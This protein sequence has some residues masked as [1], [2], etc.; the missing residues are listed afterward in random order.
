MTTPRPDALTANEEAEFR[1]DHQHAGPDAA[2]E[3]AS[4]LDPC[5]IARL[6]AT[7]EPDLRAV[8]DRWYDDGRLRFSA[9]LAGDSDSADEFVLDLLAALGSAT[10]E[11]TQVV[12]WCGQWGTLNAMRYHGNDGPCP[13]GNCGEVAYVRLSAPTDGGGS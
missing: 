9:S 4:G 1:V 2:Y 8:I 11:P 12:W 3:C 13:A 5:R 7:P 6:L 10:P